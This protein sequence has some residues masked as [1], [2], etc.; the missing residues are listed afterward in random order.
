MSNFH[1]F[2]FVSEIW[3]ITIFHTFQR[4][5]LKDFRILKFCKYICDTWYNLWF[6][7]HWEIIFVRSTVWS[8]EMGQ[9]NCLLK[10]Q[11]GLLKQQNCLLKQRPSCSFKRVF[12]GSTDNS[13]GST[14]ILLIQQTI[15][16]VQQ[17]I[18]LSHF[19]IQNCWS[20]K[21]SFSVCNYDKKSC[22]IENR[23]ISRFCN[24]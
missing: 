2:L 18:L 8:V 14:T 6:L 22:K 4:E 20:N 23:K 15:L 11:N 7:V 3:P 12:V 21:D 17:T 16:L 19:N 24:N 13:V 5:H 9:Q 10:Q 1:F